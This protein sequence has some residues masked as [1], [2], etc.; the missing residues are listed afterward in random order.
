MINMDI[1]YTVCQTA[2]LNFPV[3]F[4]LLMTTC[5][6]A[7]SITSSPLSNA[8]FLPSRLSACLPVCSP[9]ALSALLEEVCLS[10]C[11]LTTDH[12]VINTLH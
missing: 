12:Q 2:S 6:S 1:F 4:L 5:F 9:Y 10:V 11:L 8:A 3:F 7:F